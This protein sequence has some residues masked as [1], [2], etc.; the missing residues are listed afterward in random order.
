MND[1]GFDS[2]EAL[3]K[4]AAD[5][6]ATTSVPDGEQSHLALVDINTSTIIFTLINTLIIFLL[7]YFFLHKKVVAIL[8]KR[9][10][11]VNKQIDEAE[12][13]KADSA[14]IKQEYEAKLAESKEEAGRIVAAATKKAQQRE[15][16]I[17]AQA[18]SE[19]AS[20]KAKAEE[21]I[22]RDKK[23]AVNEIKDQISEIVV[24]AA[25]KVAEKEISE[26][27]NEDII[28]NFLV[29]VGEE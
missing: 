4:T 24:L 17:I 6:E 26:K 8:D 7:Y 29:N 3:L 12:Q 16:E 9:A 22:E 28:N 11:M 14:A 2:Y 23:R 13:A 25:S 19:A 18:N 1:M 5:T 20:I 21:S 10:D 27:D 15:D